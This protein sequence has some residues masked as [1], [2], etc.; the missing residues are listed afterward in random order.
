MTDSNISLHAW[1]KEFPGAVTVCDSSG[2]ILEMNEKAIHTNQ[3]QGGA[4]LIGRKRM[5]CM[6]HFVRR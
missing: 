3:E 6:P 2:V 1:I 4:Q 5:D